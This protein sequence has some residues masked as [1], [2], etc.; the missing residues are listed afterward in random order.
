MVDFGIVKSDTR[1]QEIEF[2]NESVF[3]ASN[4]EEY[5]DTADDYEIFGYKYHYVQY[6]KDEYIQKLVE[7]RADIIALQD[8]LEATK[9]LLGVE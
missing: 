7:E 9:I 3:V 8:E 6:T 1:P 5:Q 2:T 4:I